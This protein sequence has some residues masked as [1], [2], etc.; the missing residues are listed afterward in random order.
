[1]TWR[2]RFRTPRLLGLM[3][4]S[5]LVL[6]SGAP[7]TPP[8]PVSAEAPAAVT[9]GPFS[10]PDLAPPPLPSVVS[11][12]VSFSAAEYDPATLR[13]RRSLGLGAT[14]EVFAI[15]STV[16]PLIVELALRDVDAG[17]LSMNTPLTTTAATRSIE[18][19]PAGTN[20]LQTLARRAIERSDN[21]AAD[22]LH[23]RVGT[24]RLTRSVRERSPCTG[25]FL[26]GKAAWAAQGGLQ[27]EVLGD[28]LAVGAQWYSHL[29]FEAKLWTATRM[30]LGAATWTGP[31][32]EAA[33]DRYFRGPA[34]SPDID[35][36]VHTTSTARA[37]TDLMARVVPGRNLRPS[38]RRLF[39]EWLAKG[40][41][42]PKKPRL[43]AAYWG[44]KAGSGWRLL[45][46][47]GA[48]E[49]TDGRLFAYTYLNDGSDV[50]DSEDM[51]EQIPA[52]VSWIER[53]LIQLAQQ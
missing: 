44:A 14:N 8:P 42:R 50:Q 1:M 25:V 32:V 40:C 30:N 52:V 20:T 24:Q 6:T 4:I 19:Y 45:T 39:R 51:E 41:C 47:T 43:D 35:L 23:L 11:G 12:R 49:T 38:T 7:T 37:Y 2:R 48:V 13:V 27:S 5:L 36:A 29:P 15:A 3:G 33:I 53:G 21:T 10:P 26:T 9:C 28:D 22:L 17:L 18:L 46:L 34:Y 31:Q 16:K